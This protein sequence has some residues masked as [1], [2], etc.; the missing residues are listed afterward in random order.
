MADI[1]KSRS[2]EQAEL[3]GSFKQLTTEVNRKFKSNMV[4]P[5][6]VTLGDEF[7]CVL[8]SLN[9]ALELMVLIEET[10]FSLSS[11]IKLR[12]VLAKGTISS[13]INTEIGW[14]MMGEGLA[15]T[16]ERLNSLKKSR[17]R[18]CI[19]QTVPNHALLN[20]A[21]LIYESIIDGWNI[22]RDFPVIAAYT[23]TES[24]DYKEIAKLLSKNPDQIW[25]REKS[26]KIMEY[27]SIK[28]IIVYFGGEEADAKI[29]S[30]RD[31]DCHR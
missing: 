4:S 9:H 24:R 26:M 7:Q 22:E 29:S 2:H 27:Y 6:T 15:H 8:A 1:I 16:R 21:F 12:Y 17:S 18:F 25:K 28:R 20:D 19:D 13:G 10:I 30:V 3:S 5:I 14:G 23:G 31:T 11:D